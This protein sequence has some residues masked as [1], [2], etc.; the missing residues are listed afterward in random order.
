[1]PAIHDLLGSEATHR[2]TV[3]LTGEQRAAVDHL[4]AFR[5]DVQT[6]GGFAGVGKTTVIKELKRRLPRFAACAY[7]GKAAHVLTRKGVAA[8]TIHSL[9]YKPVEHEW[10]NDDGKKHVDVTWDKLPTHEVPC[11][12]FL[13]DEASM[14]GRDLHQDLV[15]HGRPIIYVGDHGQ[16]EPV[17]GGDFNLMRTPDVVLET[18]HRNAGEIARFAEFI[19]KGGEA[20][21][22]PKQEGCIGELVRLAGAGQLDDHIDADQVICAF[23]RTRVDV[24]RRARRRIGFAQDHP[25]VG[26]RVMCLQNDRDLGVFNGMQ[27]EVVSLDRGDRMTFVSDGR[28]H[29]VR[30]IPEQF[31][32]ERKPEV[33]D[34]GGRLPFD[35]AYCITTHKS[36]GSEWDSVVVL[37]QRCAVWDHAR[38]A[39]TAASRARET[40]TWV[41]GY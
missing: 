31:N 16:L 20:S 37:E 41:T 30:C 39:Y 32:Q 7:T 6:M 5:K 8:T 25:E 19:R 12:G 1:M 36:Q 15:A 2:G 10:W 27:G 35:Y 40:L 22:W 38:W 3:K 29:V 13:V 21:D 4:L 9:L 26:D 23:N 34:K 24:N 28:E 33:R 14:V 17:G 18:I 11:E